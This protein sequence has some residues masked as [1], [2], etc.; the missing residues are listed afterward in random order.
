MQ[1]IAFLIFLILFC[2]FNA[3]AQ[4]KLTKA[5]YAVYASVLK[6]LYKENRET[7]ANKSEFVFLNET[8]VDRE[9]DL[10]SE[11]KYKNLVEDFSRKN[12]T[13]GIIEKKFPSGAYSDTYYLVSQAEIDE[14]LERGRIE[15]EQRRAKAKQ[16]NPS[17]VYKDVP[18]GY[19]LP[20]FQKY[21]ESSGLHILSRVGFSRQFA[22]VQIKADHGWNGFSR[23]YVL[24]KV[25]NKWRIITFSGSTWSS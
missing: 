18:V 23:T 2:F 24:K 16:L 12:K 9:L 25:N 15:S 19:W 1:K 14:L 10:P 7:Y 4:T 5:E 6:V 21:H 11:N 8:K 3:S 13:Q 17:V 22:M 20:F